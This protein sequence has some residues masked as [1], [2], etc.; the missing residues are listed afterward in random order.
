M[1]RALEKQAAISPRVYFGSDLQVIEGRGR[2][3]FEASSIVQNQDMPSPARIPI[4][5][6]IEIENV[7]CQL[8]PIRILPCSG[9]DVLDW[10][11]SALD[12]QTLYRPLLCPQE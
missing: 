11:K 3:R 1:V 8:V 7:R 9:A 10:T 5:I 12:N 4:C 2:M 6:R